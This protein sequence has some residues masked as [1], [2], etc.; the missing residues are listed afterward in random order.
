MNRPGRSHRPISFKRWSL[1][2]TRGG[3]RANCSRNVSRAGGRGLVT[4]WEKVRSFTT[5]SKGNGLLDA[6]QLAA[7]ANSWIQLQLAR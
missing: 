5:G 1:R 2:N 7:D 6:M 3:S 4:R